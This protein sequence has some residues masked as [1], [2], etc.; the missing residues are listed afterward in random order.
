MDGE[1]EQEQGEKGEE[2]SPVSV[3]P[4]FIV[5]GAQRLGTFTWRSVGR[6]Y[7]LL[8]I[9]YSIRYFSNQLSFINLQFQ[10]YGN[11]FFGNFDK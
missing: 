10:F 1:A 11:F 3:E 4:R 8:F 9:Y 7:Q 2:V 6:F 5:K